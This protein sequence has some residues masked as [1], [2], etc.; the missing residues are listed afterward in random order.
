LQSQYV[1]NRLVINP[2]YA[3]AEGFLSTTASYRRQWLGF[4]GAPETFTFTASTPLRNKHYNI[5][6]VASQ[7]NI[8]VLH[9]TRVGLIYAYRI[10]A[11]KISFSAGFQPGVNFVKNSWSDVQTTNPGDASYQSVETG[12]NFEASYGLYLQSKRFFF[13]AS[14]VARI[15]E[16][17]N[18]APGAQPIFLVNTGYTFGDKKKTAVTVSALGRYMMNS[19]YQAD[20]NVVVGLRDRILVGASYRYLDAVVGILQL[21]IND[22]FFIGYSYDYTLSHLSTYSSGTHELML[23]YDFSFL[24]NTKS[25]RL[26]A[27]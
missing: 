16:K 23:R 22:Q 14:S 20:F 21:K 9:Q 25:P 3:G 2:A 13:G 18:V 12:V 10:Y 5:G 8:A 26:P 1:L 24:V 7:D 27:Q 4:D 17:T 19:F 6:V 15:P 11:G